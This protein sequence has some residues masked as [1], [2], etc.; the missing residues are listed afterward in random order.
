[1]ETIVE[2]VATILGIPSHRFREINFA[3][4]GTVT[5]FK[6]IYKKD[7]V[8]LHEIWQQANKESQFER[9]LEETENF[10][11]QNSYKKRGICMLPTRY[12]HYP[13]FFRNMCKGLAT[14]SLLTDGSVILQHGGI[15]MGQGL[16]TKIQ[17][18]C[19]TSLGVPFERVYTTTSN[20]YSIANAPGTGGS[21]GTDLWGS[22]VMYACEI[23]NKTLAPYK[24]KMPNKTFPEICHI[25]QMSGE[26]LVAQ[27]FHVWR[28]W[29]NPSEPSNDFLYFS[30][31]CG[32]VEVELDL[33]T[34]KFV[35]LSASAW[36]DVGQSINPAVDIGQIE[37]GLMQGFGWLTLEDLESTYRPDGVLDLTNESYV[38]PSF[39]NMPSSINI[40]LIPNSRN[41]SVPHSS[42]GTGEPPYLLGTAVLM[43]LRS[44]IAVA[45]KE[46]NK[47]PWVHIDYPLTNSRV[48]EAIGDINILSTP[49]K[50][51]PKKRTEE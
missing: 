21:T 29:W 47:Q 19:A 18:L 6:Q 22:A 40:T 13:P 32:L 23:L 24:E 9:R 48:K 35:V 28:P 11:R 12:V 3:K 16:H 33:L 49:V 26:N 31:N 46:H 36:Q 30:W 20:M 27:G 4:E 14:V 10:N 25:A 7:D 43:A 1:M 37:G 17:Q 5:H 38:I 45:R 51:L 50:P 44:A 41:P 42:K 2:H 34:G 8:L 15:E 39:K